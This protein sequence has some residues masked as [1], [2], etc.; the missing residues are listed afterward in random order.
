MEWNELYITKLKRNKE[1]QFSWLASTKNTDALNENVRLRF[2][3][4]RIV[5]IVLQSHISHYLS[6][7]F[8]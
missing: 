7:D 4:I 2:M 8:V 1:T 3:E 6:I 5:V